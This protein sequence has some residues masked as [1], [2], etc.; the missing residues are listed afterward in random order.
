MTSTSKDTAIVREELKRKV[1]ELFS[2]DVEVALFYYSGHGYIDDIGGYLVTTECEMGEDGLSLGELMTIVNNSPAKNK[3]VM[4]DSCYSGIAGK[5]SESEAFSR[6][7]EG[8]TILTSCSE[9]QYAIEENGNGVFT[10]L[11]ID[12]LYGGA[13]NLLGE[14]TPGS[15]YAH[16]DQSLGPWDQRPVFKT[17][18]K[19]FISLRKNSAPI[20]LDNLRAVTE[21][22]KSCSDELKLN[23][24]YEPTSADANKENCEKF[25]VLQKLNRVN[26]VIPVGAEHMYYAAMDNK[27]C[28]LTSLGVHYWK[29]VNKGQI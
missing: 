14:V 16:I 29:L 8:V 4:L 13:S 23:S 24:S 22:F 20:E 2:D 7:A 28:K 9:K 5:N 18:V 17:N 6:I 10:S 3:I 15:V 19:A 25:F 21:L 1:I 26:L 11:L 27:S 12:A